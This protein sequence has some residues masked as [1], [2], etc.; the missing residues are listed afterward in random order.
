MNNIDAHYDFESPYFAAIDL[1]SNSFHMIIVRIH[2]AKIEVIDREKEMIQIAN[3]I[4]SD[5]HLTDEALNNAIA[6]LQRFSERLRDIPVKQIR[7]VGTKTLR[8]VK[9]ANAFLKQAEKALGSPIQIV[10]GFE[11]AR[12]VYTGFSHSVNHD[13]HQRLVVDI[14]GGSTEFVI[15]VDY[16]PHLL[17]SLTL[18]CVIFTKQ[19]FTAQISMALAMK[20]AYIR[21]CGELESIRKPYLAK[22]W[23]TAHGTSGTIKAIA[24]LLSDEHGDAKI[25]REALNTL[26]KTVAESGELPTNS[27]SQQ[28]VNVL[29]AGIA[30][31]KAIF[32][33]LELDAIFASTA[34]LKEGL[35][36]D[37]IGRFS[38]HDSRESTI[39][40]LQQQYNVDTL[41]A[42]N[43]AEQAQTLWEKVDRLPMQGVSRTRMLRWAAKVHEIGL[44]IS[45][46]GY[47]NHAYY[48]LKHSDLAGFG[49]YEQYILSSLVR[50]HRKKIS[51]KSFDGMDEVTKSAFIPVL[52]CLR[53]AIVLNRRRD[54]IE[55][56][57]H[58]DASENAISLTFESGWLQKNPLTYS[59][60]QQEIFYLSQVG[61]EL[62]IK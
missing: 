53:I 14:G 42:N 49:R 11:E 36:Y 2:E 46:S 56:L 37:T 21:A 31:L 61:F 57:T 3:G 52:A 7:A 33:Q 54:K 62:K 24:E 19:F 12:L 4:H 13:H 23:Q 1:G 5:G 16:D 51:A 60:L 34:S 59:N 38:N 9:N 58:I 18:G 32:D 17:E 45:H 39:S 15:G 48:I 22:G 40:K 25:T 41:H 30:I 29:P 35:I 6:C 26:Y 28:R 8:S 44:N 50:A 27:L 43:V 10:S 47:H 55:Q 20:R